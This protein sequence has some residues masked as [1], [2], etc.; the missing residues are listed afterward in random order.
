MGYV[1]VSMS[2]KSKIIQTQVF[3]GLTPKIGRSDFFQNLAFKVQCASREQA[4]DAERWGACGWAEGFLSILQRSKAN[5]VLSSQPFVYY[6]HICSG[7]PCD[8]AFMGQCQA[9]V[10]T[11]CREMTSFSLFLIDIE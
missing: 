7:C 8:S 3:H 9:L 6:R 5:R 10:D 11:P 2:T 1:T 4:R